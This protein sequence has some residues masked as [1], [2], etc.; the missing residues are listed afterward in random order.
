MGKTS[1]VRLRGREKIWWWKWR[2][3]AEP[4]RMSHSTAHRS[5][6][7]KARAEKSGNNLP[8]KML[9]NETLFATSLSTRG[10][11]HQKSPRAIVGREPP[12]SPPPWLQRSDIVEEWRQQRT[13]WSSGGRSESDGNGTGNWK[14]T[15]RKGLQSRGYRSPTH[16]TIEATCTN[17]KHRKLSWKKSSGRCTGFP[18]LRAL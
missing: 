11:S 14:W 17:L 7:L 5:Y 18:G 8:K 13:P 12:W 6:P 1:K 3:T 10:E 4:W 2:T 16:R 9:A 15:E